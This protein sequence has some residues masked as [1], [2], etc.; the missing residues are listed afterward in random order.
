M[1]K[2]PLPSPD[3]LRQLLSYDPE[4]GDLTWKR[5]PASMFEDNRCFTAEDMCRRWNSRFA[6]KPA[7][8]SIDGNGY[9]FGL[10]LWNRVAAHRA[11][12]AIFHGKWPDD[13]IDHINGVPSDNRI[14]NLR[15]ATYSQNQHNRAIHPHNKAGFPGV[16]F[17]RNRNKW[18]AKIRVNWKQ[19]HLGRYDTPEA[20]AEAYRSAKRRL[21]PFAPEVRR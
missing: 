12:W 14:S 19:I 3:E 7:L 1:A 16:S 10:V 6:G 21:H 11:A 2:K 13:C 4:T 9:R 8:A 20:A 17:D 5:R 15:D 18:Q